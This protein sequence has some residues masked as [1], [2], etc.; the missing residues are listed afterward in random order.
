MGRNRKKKSAAPQSSAP[1]SQLLTF[2]STDSTVTTATSDS[3][4][5][6]P[7]SDSLS[8]TIHPSVYHD[9]FV[10]CHDHLGFK[11]TFKSIVCEKDYCHLSPEELRFLDLEINPDPA[12]LDPHSF[13][14]ARLRYYLDEGRSSAPHFGPPVP[15]FAFSVSS[16][17]KSTS[18]EGVAA[19][20]GSGSIYIGLGCPVPGPTFYGDSATTIC[21]LCAARLDPGAEGCEE[22][23]ESGTAR[24]MPTPSISRRNDTRNQKKRSRISRRVRR[25]E[26]TVESLSHG[27]ILALTEHKNFQGHSTTA[28]TDDAGMVD[29]LSTTF[30]GL[31]TVLDHH[32]STPGATA[33]DATLHSSELPDP[34]TEREGAT[35]LG[36]LFVSRE[37]KP[38]PLAEPDRVVVGH[39]GM[40]ADST[41]VIMDDRSP[42]SGFLKPILDFMTCP[43]VFRFLKLAEAHPGLRNTQLFDLFWVADNLFNVHGGILIYCLQK[44]FIPMDAISGVTGSS[45]WSQDPELVQKLDETYCKHLRPHIDTDGT[46]DIAA[47]VA[48][49][50]YC[51]EL[52]G[53]FS[54]HLPDWEPA[55]PV[56]QDLSREYD[57]LSPMITSSYIEDLSGLWTEVHPALLEVTRWLEPF[58]DYGP[59]YHNATRLYDAPIALGRH[60][61]ELFNRRGSV[62][63]PAM[64]S[65]MRANNLIRLLCETRARELK[66]M[67]REMVSV[68]SNAVSRNFFDTAG[69]AEVAA[70]VNRA[71]KVTLWRV[72]EPRDV[73]MQDALALREVR[74][75]KSYRPKL[76]QAGTAA[77]RI[78]REV[79]N[80]LVQTGQ[81]AGA[82]FEGGLM[83]ENEV[84]WDGIS[85]C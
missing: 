66:N 79:F 36:S 17:D 71:K 15:A 19:V 47:K 21:S 69:D 65:T 60:A 39:T 37:P 14:E 80:V 73:Q 35:K 40:E 85:V 32:D 41:L 67:Q 7:S 59:N 84:F 3:E 72:T 46:C 74:V 4:S 10:G 25:L 53:I 2:L 42:I 16:G 29:T 75:M 20:A 1:L 63:E 30:S 58:I 50:S 8:I 44:S 56:I 11:E 27:L 61:R 57:F 18:S 43:E 82:D 76:L 81:R 13:E 22:Y 12:L 5:T 23:E 83:G 68:M 77:A 78:R 33:Q 54:K 9:G 64:F 55:T 6:P 38:R 34:T 24:H 62:K 51:V 52:A 31:S 70:L 28:K 48:W 26:R 49:E 45:A